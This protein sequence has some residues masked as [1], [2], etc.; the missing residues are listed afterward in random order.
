MV[1]S[2]DDYY[3]EE[4]RKSSTTSSSRSKSS[5]LYLYLTVYYGNGE[6]YAG[7]SAGTLGYAGRHD[8]SLSIT[9][10]GGNPMFPNP[11]CDYVFCFVL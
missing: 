4:V 6:C 10:H 8:P 11:F 7:Y 2:G 1:A 3:H 5:T 9:K